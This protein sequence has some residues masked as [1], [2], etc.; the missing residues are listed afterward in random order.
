MISV[1]HLFMYERRLFCILIHVK[2][3]TLVEGVGE[4][5]WLITM[6]SQNN[7]HRVGCV[8]YFGM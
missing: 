7:N 2:W 3:I 4:M 1:D 8:Q 6:N 5:P